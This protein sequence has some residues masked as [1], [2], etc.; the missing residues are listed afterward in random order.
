MRPLFQLGPRL[1]LCASLVREGKA[2]CDVGTDHGYL[3]I[4]LL[5]TGKIPRALACDI[6]PGPL[7]A[8]RRDGA[9]YEA[10]EALSFRLSD[11]LREVSPEEAEDVVIAG[12]GG[13][14]I[15]RIVGETT[16]LRDKEKQLILQP[17]SSVPELRLGLRELGF[18]VLQE[19]AV[20]E[21]TKVYSAFSVRYDGAG[22]ETSP[23]YPYLGKLRPGAPHVDAYARK[24]LRELTSQRKG[25]LHTG[26]D[27][28]AAQLDGLIREVEEMY[29]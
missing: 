2:L 12:M 20:E 9:K 29:L 27:I 24:V 3:P 26:D 19:E 28:R 18:T 11:G 25:A 14:L 13:E 5:K 17:M 1:A 8:A 10:G 6:N 22:E 15:L 21:G 4:W 16:W 7:D 23:L